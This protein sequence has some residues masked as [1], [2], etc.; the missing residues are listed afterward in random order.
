MFSALLQVSHHSPEDA[1]KLISFRSQGDAFCLER[2]IHFRIYESEPKAA[3][4]CLLLGNFCSHQ[5]IPFPKMLIRFD[6][7]CTYC[8]R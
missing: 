1:G 5:K 4:L 3:F 7:I 2:S 8:T 6:V